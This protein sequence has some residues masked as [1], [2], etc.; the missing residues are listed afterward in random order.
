MRLTKELAAVVFTT[1]VAGG[2]YFA[3]NTLSP[4]EEGVSELMLA[5]VEALAS[6]PDV[7]EYAKSCISVE[8][9]VDCVKG[10]YTVFKN[11]KKID[12]PDPNPSEEED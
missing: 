7:K 1:V 2:I 12:D 6:E 4:M 11:A 10:P 5:N 3:Y 8:E 9:D